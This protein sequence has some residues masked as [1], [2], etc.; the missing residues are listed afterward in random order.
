MIKQFWDQWPNECKSGND[1]NKLLWYESFKSRSDATYTGKYNGIDIL[2]D[3]Y[4]LHAVALVF[5]VVREYLCS[6]CC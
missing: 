1:L 3:H 2:C 6:L 4:D 5:N